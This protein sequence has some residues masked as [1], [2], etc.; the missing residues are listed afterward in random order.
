MK[1]L[2]PFEL[3]QHVKSSSDTLSDEIGR[4]QK[5]MRLPQFQN[6]KDAKSFTM[7]HHGSPKAG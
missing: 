5:M 2:K 7:K 3:G 1:T 6:L 4:V